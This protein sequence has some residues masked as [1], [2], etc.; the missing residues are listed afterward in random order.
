MEHSW[1][2]DL[3]LS[4][5]WGSRNVYQIMK[6]SKPEIKVRQEESNLCFKSSWFCRNRSGS[7][8]FYDFLQSFPHAGEGERSLGVEFNWGNHLS[9]GA[10]N[11]RLFPH[12]LSFDNCCSKDRHLSESHPPT[13]GNF[14]TVIEAHFDASALPPPS[15][16]SAWPLI[17]KYSLILNPR[18]NYPGQ[19]PARPRCQHIIGPPAHQQI[20]GVLKKVSLVLKWP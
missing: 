18:D 2:P 11:I 20:Q 16:V 8:H 19:P 5:W 15:A 10:K 17:K 14:K 1:H 7:L 4:I 13:P 9:Y 12:P 3:I 6:S